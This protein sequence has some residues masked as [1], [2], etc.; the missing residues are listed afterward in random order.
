MKIKL[1]STVILTSFMAASAFAAVKDTASPS[2]KTAYNKVKDMAEAD[3][4]TEVVFTRDNFTLTPDAR[5][6]LRE[7]IFSAQKRGRVEEV[8][9][10]SWAD[11]EYPVNEKN[12][13][14]N[15]RKLADER[16]FEIRNYVED[17][18]PDVKVMSFNMAETPDAVEK[19]FGTSENVKVKKALES[20]GLAHPQKSGLPPK[21]SHALI[22]ISVKKATN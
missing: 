1:H 22:L 21:A 9:I 3:L 19:M 11:K 5:S 18:V 15:A 2:N 4:F 20:A 16:I 17:N 14:K 10:I 7:L 12:L 6:Q 13:D 8:K